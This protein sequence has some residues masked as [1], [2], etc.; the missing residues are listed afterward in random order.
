MLTTLRVIP[1]IDGQ[2]W[3]VILF[4]VGISLREIVEPSSDVSSILY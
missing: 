2:Y 4:V 3:V 1:W